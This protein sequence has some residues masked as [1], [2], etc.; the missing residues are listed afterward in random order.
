MIIKSAT[1]EIT[2]VNPDQYPKSELPEIVMLG[3][4]NVG[5]SS[6]IN[7]LTGKKNLA[8]VGS[9]P[10]K[11]R[12]LNFYN[13]NGAFRLVDLPGYGYANVSK[14]EK[15]SWGTLA[16]TYLTN[17]KQI[18]LALMIIDVRHMPSNED[19][20]MLD[21]LTANNVDYLIVGNKSDKLS[22]AQVS[23]RL[24]DIRYELQLPNHI[25]LIP[26]SSVK[27]QGKTELLHEIS[28]K[29]I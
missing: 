10:G 11:T 28:S 14:K 7:T 9:T 8:R 4:S 3:R 13:I 23:S 15:Q 2:A 18:T 27:I 19:I 1:Y 22:R 24:K 17:R 5:K 16:D 12:Q 20:M 6:V 21:W 25:K 29:I 26:F